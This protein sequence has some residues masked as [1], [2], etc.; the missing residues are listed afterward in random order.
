MPR[1]T[2][3]SVSIPQ[4]KEEV[5]QQQVVVV[6]KGRGPCMGDCCP[7]LSRG[8]DQCFGCQGDYFMN[9]LCAYPG[10]TGLTVE[11]PCL[12]FD[13]QWGGCGPCIGCFHDCPPVGSCPY[14]GGFWYPAFGDTFGTAPYRV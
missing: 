10:I 12:V 1:Q 8:C 6:D 9:P 2:Q 3:L 5:P 13:E 4:K 14:Y 7:K 11:K